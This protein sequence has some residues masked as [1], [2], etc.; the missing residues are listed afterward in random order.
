M[1]RIYW[2]ES[3]IHSNGNT[4]KPGTDGAGVDRVLT[5]YAA[6]IQIY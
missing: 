5:G 6:R 1:D 3:L 2:Y 4:K